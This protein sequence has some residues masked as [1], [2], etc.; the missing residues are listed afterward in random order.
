MIVDKEY[1]LLTLAVW[2]HVLT[3]FQID[4]IATAS[5]KI[6]NALPYPTIIS[7]TYE[8]KCTHHEMAT[9]LKENNQHY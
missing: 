6:M 8:L 2:L 5:L 4:F 1:F 3:T 9:H 7:I